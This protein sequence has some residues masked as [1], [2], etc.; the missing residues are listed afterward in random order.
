MR[1]QWCGA[2][3]WCRGGC[4]GAH[5]GRGRAAVP[6]AR[7]A[8]VAVLTAS[9]TI[10]TIQCPLSLTPTLGN[11]CLGFMAALEGEIILAIGVVAPS[12]R[13]KLRTSSLCLAALRAPL[14]SF[15]LT[16]RAELWQCSTGSFLLFSSVREKQGVMN[17]NPVILLHLTCHRYWASEVSLQNRLRPLPHT[18][19]A[20]WGIHQ[21]QPNVIKCPV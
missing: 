19:A 9:V 13:L 7:S 10:T 15:P 6:G 14:L 18:A 11:V 5:A 20:Q 16:R 2:V 4:P 8:G 1:G 17:Q 3:V 12:N 21:K